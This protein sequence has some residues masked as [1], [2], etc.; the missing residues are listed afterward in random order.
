MER[1]SLL[2]NCIPI[3]SVHNLDSN[4]LGFSGIVY[5]QLIGEEK[6]TFFENVSNPF[7]G[8]ILIKGQND[9]VRKQI[10]SSIL[11]ALMSL[12]LGI[13][14]KGFLKG[15]GG[16]ELLLHK[17]L[18]EFSAQVPGKKKL[19]IKAIANAILSIPTTLFE[20]SGF[21]IENS[22]D[23]IEIYEKNEIRLK[24]NNIE[25]IEHLD[26]FSV[27]KNIFTTL[28]FVIVQILLIDDIYFGRGLE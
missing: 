26:S 3:N 25:K 18:L 10:E 17:H 2:C 8:T 20:N 12:K 7:S 24:N 5:E 6:Y 13:Q 9:F 21:K 11:N 23:C 14:D 27:K 19:G 28:C 22:Y 16:I 1:L 4:I 15:A